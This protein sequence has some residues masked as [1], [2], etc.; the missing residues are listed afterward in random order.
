MAAKGYTVEQVAEALRNSAGIYTMAGI[1]L[2]CCGN[3]VSNFIKKHPELLELIEQ[4]T[5]QNLDL[6]EVELLK[7][8]K[9]GN[10][11]AIIFYLKTKGKHRGYVERQQVQ[12]VMPSLNVYIPE[13]VDERALASEVASKMLGMSPVVEIEVEAEVPVDPEAEEGWAEEDPDDDGY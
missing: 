2:G 3:T 1:Q 9:E 7:Q 8:I 6:A 5:E 13:T 4:V 11:A 10:I 12:A